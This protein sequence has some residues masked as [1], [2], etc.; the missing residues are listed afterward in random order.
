[1]GGFIMSEQKK[2]YTQNVILLLPGGSGVQED[3]GCAETEW[4]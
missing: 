3:C 1:M 2:Q 4:G